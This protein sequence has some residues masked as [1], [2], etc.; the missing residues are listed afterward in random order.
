MLLPVLVFHN[1]WDLCI[2][3]CLLCVPIILVWMSLCSAPVRARLLYCFIVLSSYSAF[4]FLYSRCI[5]M[6]WI[7]ICLNSISCF[8]SLCLFQL[9]SYLQ[10]QKLRIELDTLITYIFQLSTALSYLESKNFVHRYV[11][12][13][14][15][16]ERF[17]I[18]LCLFYMI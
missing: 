14:L 2:F 8:Y 15:L 5:F 4:Y 6:T 3:L 12:N 10:T 7:Q 17:R 18:L 11:E 13:Y 1:Q 16:K 9:R